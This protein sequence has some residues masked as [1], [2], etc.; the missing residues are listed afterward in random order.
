MLVADE[1]TCFFNITTVFLI[2]LIEIIRVLASI[3]EIDT[4]NQT[5]H[6]LNK[7]DIHTMLKFYLLTIYPTLAQNV[8][9]SRNTLRVF[10]FQILS[11]QNWIHSFRIM[12][13]MRSQKINRATRMTQ[14]H[15][16]LS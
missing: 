13:E 10:S 5:V 11:T 4:I 9:L 7:R 2:Y 16:P 8:H 1:E 3:L 14:D 6:K 15:N 12:I